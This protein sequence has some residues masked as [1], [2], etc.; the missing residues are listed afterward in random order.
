VRKVV[1]GVLILA[2]VAAG[3]WL[4]LFESEEE[5]KGAHE[6]AAIGRVALYHGVQQRHRAATGRYAR[7]LAELVPYG[8]PAGMAE[9]QADLPAPKADHGYLYTAPLRPFGIIG[10]PAQP[11]VTGDRTFFTDET[12]VIR[13]STVAAVSLPEAPPP[14]PAPPP[15]PPADRAA[16][17]GEEAAFA[18]DLYR[19]LAPA[20][21]G[22]AFVVSPFGVR[23]AL[24]PAADGARGETETELRAALRMGLPPD[25]EGA[26]F[27]SAIASARGAA[28]AQGGGAAA[29]SRP[30]VVAACYFP[31]RGWPISPSWLERSG[32]RYGAA[33][34]EVDFAGDRD[35]AAALMNAWAIRASGA[36]V[37]GVAEAR[38]LDPATALACVGIVALDGAWLSPFERARTRPEPFTLATGE[39]VEAP[40]MMQG[41]EVGYLEEEGLQVARL[42]YEGTSLCFTALLPRAHDGLAALERSLDG[43]RLRSLVDRL[44]DTY[45]LVHLPRFRTRAAHALRPALEAL[46]ARRVFDR[47]AADLKGMLAE[48]AAPATPLHLSGCDQE[49]VIEVDEEGTAALAMT[50]WTAL[51]GDS[52]EPVT[53]PPPPEFRADRPFLYLVLD[54]ASGAVLFAGRVTDPRPER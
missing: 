31:G 6:A 21:P 3:A 22:L 9:A 49:A 45:A 16:F 43:P 2:V 51:G 1:V 29:M 34:I 47:R 10:L 50:S 12:G 5:R 36:R 19:A 26:A 24:A 42:D 48:G 32:A 11:G 27:A 46:G 20:D 17:A 7:T 53:P 33:S 4:A 30:T 54:R 14:A 13:M 23:A 8:L 28:S 41:A 18:L 38:A 44:R 37:A 35:G 39:K 40:L 52:G 25:R 15:I